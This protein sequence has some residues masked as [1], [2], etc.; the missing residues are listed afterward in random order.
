MIAALLLVG[1][2]VASAA[3]AP[4]PFVLVDATLVPGGNTLAGRVCQVREQSI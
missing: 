3:A 2:S 4:N 1:T